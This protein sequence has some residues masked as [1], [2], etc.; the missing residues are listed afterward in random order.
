MNRLPS[1]NRGSI[2]RRD[3]QRDPGTTPYQPTELPGKPFLGFGSKGAT[4]EDKLSHAGTTTYYTWSE[5][6]PARPG[7]EVGPQRSKSYT[8][9]HTRLEREDGK[10]PSGSPL[11]AHREDIQ[12]APR[13]EWPRSRRIGGP[14]VVQEYRPALRK[15][16][17]SFGNTSPTRTTQQ[18][19]PK[20]HST[21]FNNAH[22]YSDRSTHDEPH[23]PHSGYRTSDILKIRDGHQTV[24]L[25][26]INGFHQTSQTPER[27]KENVDPLSS[28]SIDGMLSRV[29]KAVEQPASEA[30]TP[31]HI[32]HSFVALPQ[33]QARSKGQCREPLQRHPPG[34]MPAVSGLPESREH[35]DGF[36]RK[37][38][39]QQNL[40]SERHLVYP[41]A[42][43]KAA[44]LLRQ[45]QRVSANTH[46]V[47]PVI[48]ITDMEPLAGDEEMLDS[49]QYYDP[50]LYQP[51]YQPLGQRAVGNHDVRPSSPLRHGIFEA[52]ESDHGEEF[53]AFLGEPVRGSGTVEHWAWS[54]VSNERVI[55]DAS[56][57]RPREDEG[58]G[59]DLDGFWRPNKLY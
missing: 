7:S 46:F 17:N 33:A 10:I 3:S 43:P 25:E 41:N 47:E 32:D 59:G 31:L 18:S 52:Q 16:R 14:A 9:S 5:S 34:Q 30:Q 53:T 35:L 4:P 15:P 11:S 45:A 44:P 36:D 21:A 2:P 39:W 12:Q 51:D 13:G 58:G 55:A 26:P 23:E 49:G 57:R 1:K 37:P 24:V 19:L 50:I 38:T 54:E 20:L 27:D 42:L 22:H 56:P 48:D 6:A 40:R 29:R 8:H 28:M